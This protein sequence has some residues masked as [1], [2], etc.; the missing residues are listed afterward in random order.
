MDNRCSNCRYW[1]NYYGYPGEDN[2]TCSRLGLNNLLISD[3]LC[4][5]YISF[6]NNANPQS[7]CTGKNFGCILFE[8]L[9]KED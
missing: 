1:N 7:V 3:T 9:E 8:K 5:M 4:S 6:H 2:G